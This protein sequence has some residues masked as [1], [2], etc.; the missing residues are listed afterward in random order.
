MSQTFIKHREDFTCRQCGAEVVGDG[1]TNHCPKCLY[2]RH[3]DICPGDRAAECGGLMAPVAV[4]RQHAAERIIHRCLE[5]GT[6]RPNRASPRDDLAAI[7]L[8]LLQSN[9]YKLNDNQHYDEK[10]DNL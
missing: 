4:E 8:L 5:C 3:V 2:S 9:S 7:S 1:Y 10:S 6:T